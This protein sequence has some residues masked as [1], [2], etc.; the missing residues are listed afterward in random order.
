MLMLRIK[1]NLFIITASS[2]RIRALGTVKAGMPV[3]F[4]LLAA[5]AVCN[6][7]VIVY[8]RAAV[9]AGIFVN[10]KQTCIAVC[11]LHSRRFAKTRIRMMMPK[12]YRIHRLFG[13]N[14]KSG[15]R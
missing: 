12:R 13:I 4:P 15:C 11:L 9:R 6:K 1:I 7:T 2:V 3:S 10:R 14:R 8:H 5:A